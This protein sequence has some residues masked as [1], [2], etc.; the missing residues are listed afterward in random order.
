M[1]KGKLGFEVDFS[2]GAFKFGQVKER[3]VAEAA[4]AAWSI[5]DDSLDGAVRGVKGQ[6]G[7]GCDQDAMVAGGALRGRNT[8]EA[9]Q[10]DHVVPDVGVV[11][12]VGGVD[13][14]SVGGKA[15]GTHTGCTVEGVDLQTRVV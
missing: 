3:I 6:A 8:G 7:S 10:E 1:A 4:G 13:Q 12:G 9:L 15:R 2:H 11:V 5:E 14:A